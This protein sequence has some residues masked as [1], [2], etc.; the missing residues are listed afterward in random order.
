ML[1][2]SHPDSVGVG[3]DGEALVQQVASGPSMTIKTRLLEIAAVAPSEFRVI[4][5]GNSAGERVE[6]IAGLVKVR[7][8]YASQDSVTQTLVAGEMI[9]INRDIDLMETEKFDLP[10]TRAWRDA[11]LASI[12]TDRR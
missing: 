2:V 1:V 10:S 5:D 6:V 7:K 11:L 4:A 8:A 9:L 3:V 12:A